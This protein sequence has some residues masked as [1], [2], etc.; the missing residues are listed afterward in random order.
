VWGGAIRGDIASRAALHKLQ[1][2]AGKP[3]SIKITVR[4]GATAALTDH[5]VAVK[6]EFRFV[7]SGRKRN[8]DLT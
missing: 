1:S 4:I 5:D 8:S 7:S 2:F 3:L 6:P